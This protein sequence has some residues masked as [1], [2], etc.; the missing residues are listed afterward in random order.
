MIEKKSIETIQNALDTLQLPTLIT[1]E[2]IK[3]QYRYLSKKE[4]PDVGGSE[5]KQEQLNRA[6]KVL[7]DYIEHYRYSFDEDEIQSQFGGVCYDK[8]F[9]E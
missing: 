7:M 5:E 1:K 2:D 4:H 6:Y 3:K 9:K 8:Y